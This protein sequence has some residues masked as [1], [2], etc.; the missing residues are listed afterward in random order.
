VLFGPEDTK[1]LYKYPWYSRRRC[2]SRVSLDTDPLDA[3][4]LV[5]HAHPTECVL[6]PGQILF[7][8]RG[9]WHFVVSLDLSINLNFFWKTWPMYLRQRIVAPAFR[10]LGVRESS[11]VSRRK[12]AAAAPG[13]DRARD[14]V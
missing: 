13:R 10:A 5:G 4:P 9:F 3:F 8:P 14:A 7:I 2:F 12:G 11:W 6:S 1:Y